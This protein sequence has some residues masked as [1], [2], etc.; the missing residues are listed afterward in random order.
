MVLFCEF[1]IIST[2]SDNPNEAII[3]LQNDRLTSYNL[4]I[5]VQDELTKTYYELREVYALS[6]FGKSIANLTPD[7]IIKIIKAYPFVISE[8]ETK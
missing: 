7:N 6:T 2:S 1:R 3:S 5:Q 4:F 8:A